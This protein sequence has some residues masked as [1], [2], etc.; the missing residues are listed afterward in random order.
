MV[1]CLVPTCGNK[2]K[3]RGLC[4]ACYQ[5]AYRNVCSGA[6]TWDE[7]IALGLS[8]PAGKP[9][10]KIKKFQAALDEARVQGNPPEPFTLIA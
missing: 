7:L 5:T 3:H 2:V 6:T 9:G 10:R 4:G 8:L 1:K